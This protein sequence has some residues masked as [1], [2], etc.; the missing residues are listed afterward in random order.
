MRLRLRVLNMITFAINIYREFDQAEVAF[1]RILK[2]YPDAELVA[3]TD[4]EKPTL[5]FLLYAERENVQIVE[6][7]R[8]YH[9]DGGAWVRRWLSAALSLTD[10]ETIVKIDPDTEILRPFEIPRA[11]VFGSIWSHRGPKAWTLQGGFQGITRQAAERLLSSGILDD[12]TYKKP[13]Y[14]ANRLIPKYGPTFNDARI[15][16]RSVRRLGLVVHDHP[17]IFCCVRFPDGFNPGPFAVIHPD[18][19]RA[20][21]RPAA[22]FKILGIGLPK[23]G[24]TS[25]IDALR[26]LG[27]RAVHYPHRVDVAMRRNDGA[28]D[29]PIVAAY[30]E[31]DRKYPGSKFVLTL[32]DRDSWLRSYRRHYSS[33]IDVD[34]MRPGFKDLLIEL[35]RIV[36]GTEHLS[37]EIVS[38][39]YDRH[40]DEVREY[41]KDRPGD[42][43]E[44]DICG[45]DGWSPLCRFLGSSI[46][47]QP[48][49]HSNKTKRR[50]AA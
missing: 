33:A 20:T 5:K 28:A 41:F 42:L 21:C 45:G 26:I 40:V 44:L 11:D 10:S 31:L 46:P 47:P 24:T 6:G 2:A 48:F 38:D 1:D 37:D 25:F 14:V 17:E 32:R 15:F 23:T 8:L 30:Q 13:R 49:P 16:S 3:I 39:G 19:W 7:V 27:F 12:P 9:T 35:R 4:G 22:P 18:T 43:L 36:F 34:K 29:L 50:A